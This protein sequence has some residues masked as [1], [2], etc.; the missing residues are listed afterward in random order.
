M[1]GIDLVLRSEPGTG[2]KWCSRIGA[3]GMMGDKGTD[4]WGGVVRVAR[5]T[6][7]LLGVRNGR[8]WHGVVVS[9]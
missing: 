7:G 6:M 2:W 9:E 5:L 4:S 3:K 1:M 8:G